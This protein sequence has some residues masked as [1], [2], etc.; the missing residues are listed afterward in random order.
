MAL[1]RE[2]GEGGGRRANQLIK[3]PLGSNIELSHNFA[4]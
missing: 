2:G 1:A 4:K 3:A